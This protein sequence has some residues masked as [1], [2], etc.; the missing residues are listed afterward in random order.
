MKKILYIAPHL[1]TGG[2]PQ[3]LVKTIENIKDIFEIYLVEY[4]DCTGGK[5][6]VQ[7]NRILNLV[8]SDKFFTLLED[9][10]ELLDI[11]NNIQPDIIHMEEIPEFFMDYN[12]TKQI[13]DI[14]RPYFI[15]E[16]SHDSSFDINK[17]SFFPDKFLF[18][19]EWQVQ[20]YKDINIPKQVIYYPI[21]YQER[22]NRNQALLDLGLDPNK[23]H[24]LHV[25]LFTPRKNQKEFFEYAIN[26]PEYEFHCVG[27]QA[28]NFKYYWEPL[29]KHKPKNLTWWNERTDVDNFYKAMDL[30][31][32]TSRGTETDKETMPLVI[33]EALAYKMNI[34]IYDL[35]VY[36]SYFDQFDNIKYLDFEDFEKNI[37]RIKNII[38][39][40]PFKKEKTLKIFPNEEVFII[41]T[42]PITDSIIST[43]KE[44]IESVKNIGRKVILTSHIPIPKELSDIVDY[45]IND[46]NNILTKHTFYTNSWISTEDYKVNV[47]LKGEN[48]DIYHGPACYSNY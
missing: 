33:R 5:L 11:I 1:S 44:C 31:L 25:G 34:L 36:L 47:N 26:L 48:N 23:K 19:S 41:S 42:Y 14:N 12:L 43:T 16:T 45:C 8:D 24:I 22:P 9:K 17:K 13:Y 32:F 7:R 27:N 39:G 37:E 46:N 2:L 40:I 38:E 30:F 10:N 35:P 15:V 18:V 6:V 28:D 20:Q 29:M 21:E 3:Y 4:V